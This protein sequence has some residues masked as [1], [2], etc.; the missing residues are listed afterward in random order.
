MGAGV[1]G[2]ARHLWDFGPWRR[3]G[4]GD[5]ACPIP[6]SHHLGA[7]WMPIHRDGLSLGLL[8]GLGDSRPGI[9]STVPG[10]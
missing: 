10:T 6:I 4:Q 3:G 2:K 7:P 1:G 5:P 8:R 9:T